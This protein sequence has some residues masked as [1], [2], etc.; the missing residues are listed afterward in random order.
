M[1][2][3]RINISYASGKFIISYKGIKIILDILVLVW[4]L[5]DLLECF[6]NIQLNIMHNRKNFWRL[7][8]IP[9]NN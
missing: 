1:E 6:E 4:S 9:R 2:H 5:T 8:H 3:F 7:T